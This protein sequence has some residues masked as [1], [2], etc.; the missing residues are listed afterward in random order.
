[1]PQHACPHCDCTRPPEAGPRVTC[2]YC[3]RRI[4]LSWQNL[5]Y[6]RV[7]WRDGKW[8]FDLETPYIANEGLKLDLEAWGDL[9]KKTKPKPPEYVD[10]DDGSEENLD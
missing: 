10:G 3:K 8:S 1:M 2:C 4:H 5:Y 9:T 7:P 6:E